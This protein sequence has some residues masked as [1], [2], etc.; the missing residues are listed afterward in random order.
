MKKIVIQK[1]VDLDLDKIKEGVAKA[2]SRG[3]WIKNPGTY[4]LKIV[5]VELKGLAG[6]PT[7]TKYAVSYESTN[8]DKFNQ[9]LLVPTTS[10]NEYV[11]H[12]KKNPGAKPTHYI[13]VLYLEFLNG[14]GV[15]ID[16]T[17]EDLRD[18]DSI[19]EQLWSN[20]KENLIGATIKMD[21]GYKG[22]H[23]RYMG[24]NEDDETLFQAFNY[25]EPFAIEGQP[26]LG[27][28]TS[29]QACI[30][31]LLA[32]GVE[33]S[34]IKEFPEV[35]KTYAGPKAYEFEFGTKVQAASN[36]DLPF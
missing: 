24:K 4:T 29:K 30:N 8:G 20:P 26:P 31:Q 23:V 7:W 27:T 2:S 22:L 25:D 16:A 36:D 17:T 14:I 9:L 35:L 5:G 3:F 28:C 10:K 6:D 32:Y 15:D 19:T 34:K 12:N 18:I 1:N 13:F 11:Y 21:I 33:E